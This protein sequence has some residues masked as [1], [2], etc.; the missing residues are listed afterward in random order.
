MLYT[1]ALAHREVL[2]PAVWVAHKD[3][4]PL[5]AATVRAVV[6]IARARPREAV[7]D[8]A[9]HCNRGSWSASRDGNLAQH[10]WTILGRH[11]GKGRPIRGERRR[12]RPRE[13]P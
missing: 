3:L 11:E 10:R 9:I 5:G 2:D 6:Q 7:N 4:P 1:L 13:P 8:V 12:E